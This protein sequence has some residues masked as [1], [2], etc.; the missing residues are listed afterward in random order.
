MDS[1]NE[2]IKI[3]EELQKYCSLRSIDIKESNSDKWVKF[4]VSIENLINRVKDL[5]LENTALENTRNMCPYLKTSGIYCD[6]KDSI[7]KSKIREKIEQYKK[8]MIERPEHKAIIEIHINELKELL[9]EE[10]NGKM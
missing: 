5:E 8:M 7:P 10:V 9:G 4:V 6:Y 3:L 1:L 2:D